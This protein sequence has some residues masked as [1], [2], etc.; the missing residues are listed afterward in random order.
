MDAT[1][2]RRHKA[3]DN[4]ASQNIV[5]TEK[6]PVPNIAK[7]PAFEV[8]LGID[9]NHSIER[10]HTRECNVCVYKTVGETPAP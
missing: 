4:D 5:P 10:Q 3:G 6:F 1:Q 8:R 9:G 7:T 2:L